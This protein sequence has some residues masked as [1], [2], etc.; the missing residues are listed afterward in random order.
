MEE[1]VRQLATQLAALTQQHQAVVAELQTA[2]Q[3]IAA[4]QPNLV[5]AAAAQGQPHI[6]PPKPPVFSGRNREPSPQNWVHQMETYLRASSV[7]LHNPAAVT[8]AAGFLAD[9]ALTWYRMHLADVARGII[10][11]YA[12]WEEF[13]T[14]LI[15][16]FTPISPE[17]TA[18]QKLVTLK[19]RQSV[20]AYAQ[21]FNMCMIELPEMNEKDRIFRF[22]E[23]LKPEVRIHVEL[24]NPATLAEAI[25]WAIQ[26]DSLVWQIKTGPPLVGRHPRQIVPTTNGPVP[27][28]LGAMNPRR[29][30]QKDK[31][32]VV[33][34][35]CKGL[36]H[37]KR[38]CPKLV[39]KRPGFATAAQSN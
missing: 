33:C 24:K 29:T 35:Y 32:K 6:K 31:N 30:V 28:E 18:R 23:G 11:D 10:Q 14:D 2:R 22:L 20:R 15:T 16:R 3:Q 4:M 34:Y 37:F 13:R 19:Q 7:D 39:K 21:E 5:A 36:G 38:E 8:H 1:Q 25:E 17:R 12:N 27:M 9:S 26:T